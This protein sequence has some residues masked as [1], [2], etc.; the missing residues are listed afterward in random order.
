MDEP[1]R[2]EAMRSEAP[3]NG[4]QQTAVL[5]VDMTSMVAQMVASTLSL[6]LRLLAQWIQRPVRGYPWQRRHARQRRM[7]LLRTWRRTGECPHLWGQLARVTGAR[8][9]YPSAGLK[10]T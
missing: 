5:P 9:A 7:Q 10:S 2:S 8:S 1:V 4:A 6:E 3:P